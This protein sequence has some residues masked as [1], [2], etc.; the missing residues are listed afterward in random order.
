MSE[1]SLAAGL[2]AGGGV[3]PGPPAPRQGLQ[4]GDSTMLQV[5]LAMVRI[6][7]YV[8]GHWQREVCWCSGCIA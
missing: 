5:M 2:E 1:D 4:A 3:L 7:K 6:V 8:D